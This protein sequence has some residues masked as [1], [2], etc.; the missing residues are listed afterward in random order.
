M[1]S[2][3]RAE[4]SALADLFTEVGPDQPTLCTGWQTRDLAAHLVLRVR[5]PDAAFGIWVKALAGHTARVQRRLADSDWPTLV[6]RV[7]RVGIAS[8]VDEPMNLVEYFVHHED[9]RRAQPGWEPRVLD[10]ALAAALWSRVRLPARL[11][12]RRTPATVV[13]TAP[14]FGQVSAGRGGE[15]TVNLSGPPGEL[16]MFLLGRQRHSRVEL[17]GPEEI[18]SRMR[19]AHYGL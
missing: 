17:S 18:V 9:V 6:G 19:N 10:P 15:S 8:L 12:L 7:R 1:T 13:L 11:G 16:V 4:R 3:A 2:F 14:S 5:R